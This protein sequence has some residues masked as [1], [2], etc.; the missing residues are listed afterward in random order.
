MR[1]VR[2]V[3]GGLSVGLSLCWMML[4]PATT[5]A[6]SEWVG[7]LAARAAVG[8]AVQKP[9]ARVRVG[10]RTVDVLGLSW[11]KSVAL[12]QF[13]RRD[14]TKD[15]SLRV[16]TLAISDLHRGFFVPELGKEVS[17]VFIEGDPDRPVVL[18]LLYSKVDE[19][20]PGGDS[21][22]DGTGWVKIRITFRAVS[23]TKGSR[24]VPSGQHAMAAH[25]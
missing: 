12:G 1:R 13:D 9:S 17:I 6:S 15:D 21:A 23:R 22:G 2:C 19:V 10:D 4:V 14:P 24:P 18:G 20:A 3:A 16:V 25:S 11:G 5:A 7:P 8:A